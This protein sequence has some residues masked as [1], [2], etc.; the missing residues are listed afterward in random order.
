MVDHLK[1]LKLQ[2]F[3]LF[4]PALETASEN[5]LSE[6]AYPSA[7][8][9]QTR[10]LCCAT[11]PTPNLRL[12]LCKNVSLIYNK[13]KGQVEA[14][15]VAVDIVKLAQSGR[16]VTT[17]IQ[18]TVTAKVNCQAFLSKV[19]P[20]NPG[21]ICLSPAIALVKMGDKDVPPPQPRSWA[22]IETLLVC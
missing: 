18:Q 6:S 1:L 14:T 15:V 16:L 7:F 5:N 11:Q 21:P 19:G 9:D 12:V 8:I 20:H 13:T 17:S 3:Q 10:R 2:A 4:C 22:E